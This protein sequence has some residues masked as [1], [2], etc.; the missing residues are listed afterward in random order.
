VS[1]ERRRID[2]K[3]ETSAVKS[4]VEPRAVPKLGLLRPH[5]DIAGANN[6]NLRTQSRSDEP[7]LRRVRKSGILRLRMLLTAA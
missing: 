3:V 6:S 1:Y 4:V 2:E 7:R 5:R